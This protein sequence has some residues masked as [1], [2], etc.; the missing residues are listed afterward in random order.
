MEDPDLKSKPHG[1]WWQNNS[2]R[3]AS[4]SRSLYSGDWG[5]P[6]FG[7]PL[8]A[9]EN[10]IHFPLHLGLSKALEFESLFLA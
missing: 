9:A 6:I 8:E 4:N 2:G 7:H 5:P 1:P 3:A 10:F